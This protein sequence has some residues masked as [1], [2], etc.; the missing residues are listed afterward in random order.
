MS[1]YPIALFLHVSGAIG[2]FVGMG[3]WLFGLSAMRRAQHVEQVRTLV[4]L[5]GLTGPLFILPWHMGA[6]H[7]TYV[8]LRK[9]GLAS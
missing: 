8:H 3:I 5:V 4:H 6:T 1:I 2:Y 7:S 9:R